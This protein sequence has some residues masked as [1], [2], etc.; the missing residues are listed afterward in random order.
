MILV[1][2]GG[3]LLGCVAGLVP[4]LH[5][6]LLAVIIAGLNFDAWLSCVFLV[7]VAVSRSVVDAVPTVFLG[8]SDD[9]LA[10]FPG[11]RLLKRGQGLSAVKFCV[12]G[13]VVGVIVG[14][15]LI[16]VF[17]FIFPVLSSLLRPFL[18][19]LISGIMFFLLFRD[20]WWSFVVFGVSGL[21]GFLALNSLRDPLF[22][23]LSGLFGASGLFLSVLDDF[24]V[25]EQVDEDIRIRSSKLFSS[26]GFGVL[27]GSIVTLFPGLSPAQSASLIDVKKFTPGQ[28]LVLTGALG[29]VDVVVSLVTFFILDKARN[30]AIVVVDRLVG[31]LPFEGFLFLVVVSCVAVGLAGIFALLISNWFS[32]F[33]QVVNYS[34]MTWVIIIFLAVMSWVLSGW[35][36][37]V[38][39]FFSACVGLIAP[40]TGVSRTH[41]MGCLLLPTLMFLW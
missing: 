31:T 17:M 27:A 26:I 15:C 38:V 23:L 36:G 11:H 8:Y 28:Y 14:V 34:V 13:S 30:G 39:F 5:S 16:P 1:V 6:N 12:I 41:A 33:V 29:T 32:A 2:L 4:G 10:L 20:R 22:P 21:I 18:F 9:I 37:L 7:A 25:P 19:W 3:I 40:L 24:F 35:L